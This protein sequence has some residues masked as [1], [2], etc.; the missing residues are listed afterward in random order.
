MGRE[1]KDPHQATAFRIRSSWLVLAAVLL[2]GLALRLI[3]AFEAVHM[4]FNYISDASRYFEWA[5]KILS[6][7]DPSLVYHQSPLYPHFLALVIALFGSSVQSVLLVQAALG[8]INCFLVWLL[9]RVVFA[10]DRIGVLAAFLMAVSGPSI[11]Y[12]GIMDMASLVM[13][14]CLLSVLL[15]VKAMERGR[16]WRWVLAGLMLG[17]C[18]LTRGV[19][20]FFLPFLAVFLVVRAGREF[21]QGGPRT[22]RALVRHCLGNA[23]LPVSLVA[24][25]TLLALSPA[26]IRNYARG[27]DFVL[28]ATHYGIAFFEGNN[29]R[30][31]GQYTEPPGLDSLSD[32]DGTKI[33]EYLEGRSLAPSQVAR[34]WLKE[35]WKFV[36]AR[37]LAEAGLL[38]R[39]AAYFWNQYEIPNYENYYLGKQ[40]SKVLRL[41]LITFA[42]L[43][44]FGL[45]GMALALRDRNWKAALVVVFVLSYMTPVVLCLVVGRYRVSVAPFLAMFAAYAVFSLLSSF[46][47]GDYRRL[48]VKSA[49]AAAFTL[50]VFFPVPGLN[51]ARDY[52]DG[53]NNIGTLFLMAGKEQEAY[54]LYKMAI[55]HDPDLEGPYNNLARLLTDKNRAAEALEQLEK[56]LA[57]HPDWHFTRM[58]LGV[59][60]S[61]LGLRERAGQYFAAAYPHLP[62]SIFLRKKALELGFR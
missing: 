37:P 46:Q 47:S 17:L 11:F 21:W 12:D 25:S 31:N 7:R 51:A 6:G 29:P 61:R 45:L 35:S 50:L 4:P 14:F 9:S 19:A 28:I 30:A 26:T 24:L 55:R 34:F 33:A 22:A 52:A 32:F 54:R 42:A 38:A 20:L 43:G 27:G 44:A 53:L 13:T 56:A 18:A 62:Y 48:A 59:I 41:P 39:K 58:N 8:T 16:W 57:D 60:C 40:Y 5:E 1:M 3:H 15:V 49:G 10:S 36:S 2:L 23:A